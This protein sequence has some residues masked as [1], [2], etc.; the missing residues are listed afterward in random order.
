M[1]LEKAVVHQELELLRT[2]SSRISGTHKSS[3]E[4]QGLKRAEFTKQHVAAAQVQNRNLLCIICFF[5]LNIKM[6]FSGFKGSLAK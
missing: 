3:K 5:L 4:Q 6:G 1:A 2:S